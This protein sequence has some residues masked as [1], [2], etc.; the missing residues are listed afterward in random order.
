MVGKITFLS[1]FNA[2]NYDMIQ[3]TFSLSVSVTASNPFLLKLLLN[4]MS[5]VEEGVSSQ[6]FNGSTNYCS[7]PNSSRYF[8]ALQHCESTVMYD[9]QPIHALNF[10]Q[11]L[12]PE[13]YK[14][15]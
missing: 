4:L 14:T 8:C 2:R 1:L 6:G 13:F 5:F 10:L 15:L 9:Y 7:I 12:V 3:L 11:R